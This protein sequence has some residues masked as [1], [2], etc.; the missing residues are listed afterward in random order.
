MWYIC[1]RSSQSCDDFLLKR[2]VFL[3]LLIK[4][5]LCADMNFIDVPKAKW[6]KVILFMYTANGD[7]TV[8]KQ[9]FILI[10]ECLAQLSPWAPDC[11]LLRFV[12]LPPPPQSGICT[13]QCVEA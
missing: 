7:Q 8:V 1:F 13:V 9:L 4:E 2:N 10:V 6:L 11:C 5:F 3:C 12:S